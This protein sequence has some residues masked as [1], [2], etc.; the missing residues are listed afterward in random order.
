[1]SP[2]LECFFFSEDDVKNDY[3]SQIIKYCVGQSGGTTFSSVL[4]LNPAVWTFHAKQR[5]SSPYMVLRGMSHEGIMG[6]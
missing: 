6:C 3:N 1:M 2:S 5:V 4:A